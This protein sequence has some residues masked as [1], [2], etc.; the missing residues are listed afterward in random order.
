MKRCEVIEPNEVKRE[1]SEAADSN[2]QIKAH[3]S[4][5]N[6]FNANGAHLELGYFGDWV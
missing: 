3:F 5:C 1:K 2:L 4:A 6:W